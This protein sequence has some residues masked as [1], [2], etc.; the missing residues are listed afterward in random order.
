M[1]RTE[2]YTTKRKYRRQQ[3][4][5]YIMILFFILEMVLLFTIDWR[6]KFLTGDVEETK[7][8]TLAMVALGIMFIPVF[9]AL[10]FNIQATWTLRA[11]SDE[12]Q[13][14]Y[15]NKNIIHARLFWQAILSENY[16]EAKRLYNLDNFIKGSLR[17]LCNGII[18]GCVNLSGKD[19]KWNEKAAQRMEDILMEEE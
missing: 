4:I 17:V 14:M 9:F 5:A 1:T 15:R 18:M 8:L 19:A 2:R 12:R 3:W 7:Q 11:L 6:P 10:H 13:R 16:E